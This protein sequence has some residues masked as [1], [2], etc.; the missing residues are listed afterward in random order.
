MFQEPNTSMSSKSVELG[1]TS[2]WLADFGE[3][4]SRS[5]F[6]EVKSEPGTNGNGSRSRQSIERDALRKY[7]RKR[8]LKSKSAPRP[9]VTTLSFCHNCIAFSLC[10]KR[11]CPLGTAAASWT[12]TT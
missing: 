2:G 5:D 3:S 8:Y 12:W 7:V 4:D 10:S 1:E 9:I 11:E 6:Q